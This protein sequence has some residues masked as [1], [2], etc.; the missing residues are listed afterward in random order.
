VFHEKL[1]S[2]HEEMKRPVSKKVQKVTVRNIAAQIDIILS[3][4]AHA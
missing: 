1:N 2:A 4:Q 3:R